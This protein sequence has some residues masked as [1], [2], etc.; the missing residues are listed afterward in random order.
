MGPSNRLAS[1]ASRRS[2]RSRRFFHGLP[3]LAVIVAAF[4]GACENP[5]APVSCGSVPPLTAVHVG[6]S[7]RVPVCFDD[8]NG[9]RL[10]VYS[11]SSNRAVATV[12][13][14]R[15]AVT[16]TGVGPGTATVTVTARDPD[17]LSSTVSFWVTVPGRLTNQTG[18]SPA[19]SP[20]G[21]RIAF[22]TMYRVSDSRG[23]GEIHVMNAD[24]GGVTNLTISLASDVS[25][26]WSPDGTRIAFSSHWNRI[27]DIYVMNSDGSV[28][29]SLAHDVTGGFAWSP[30][31]RQ[32]AFA[33]AA[34]GI[35]VMDLPVPR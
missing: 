33:M 26:A 27:T 19:W 21:T 8:G 23:Q 18:S 24:G 11:S 9:D 32:I 30:D 29:T 14:G 13:A 1:A 7:A 34:S 16:G 5:L 12:T 31:G 3:A 28:V 15:S 25:P 22:Q 17:G 2:R 20:D 4:P 35:Y 10:L 6:A